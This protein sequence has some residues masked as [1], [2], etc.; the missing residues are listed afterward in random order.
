MSNDLEVNLTKLVE[1]IAESK[2]ITKHSKPWIDS[3]ISALVDELRVSK[4]RYIRHRSMLNKR[5]YLDKREETIQK[6]DKAREECEKSV[7]TV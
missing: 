3:E 7:K 4:K 6:I 5:L 2:I 1:V